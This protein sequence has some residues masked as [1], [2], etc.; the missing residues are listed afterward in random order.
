MSKSRARSR[1]PGGTAGENNAGGPLGVIL[2]RIVDLALAGSIFLVPM[3]L[4]GRHAVGR[5]MLVALAMVAAVAW[6]LRQCLSTRPR[7][8]RSAAEWLLV[9]GV[10]LLIV[11]LSPLPPAVL[12]HLSPHVS[13]ILRK[14]NVVSRTQAVIETAQLDFETILGGDSARNRH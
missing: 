8:Q 7:W 14:L 12:T 13:E 10:I 5:L 9:A 3:L 11:Q 1:T 4:G 2:L 6:S